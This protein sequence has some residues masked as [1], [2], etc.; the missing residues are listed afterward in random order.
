MISEG[1]ELVPLLAKRRAQHRSTS[2]STTDVT[3]YREP[4]PW[5]DY[6]IAYLNDLCSQMKRKQTETHVGG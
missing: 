1:V 3:K 6:G 4:G 2:L 5:H